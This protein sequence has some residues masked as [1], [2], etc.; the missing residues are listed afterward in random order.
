MKQG[1]DRAHTMNIPLF[2]E[3]NN[4]IN[5]NNASCDDDNVQKDIYHIQNHAQTFKFLGGINTEYKME[6]IQCLKVKMCIEA[7]RS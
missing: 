7:S 1:R 3:G 2:N 4:V 6:S 5:N